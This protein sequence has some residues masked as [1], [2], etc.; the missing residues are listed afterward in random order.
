MRTRGR[1]GRAWLGPWPTTCLQHFEANPAHSLVEKAPPPLEPA[2]L[3]YEMAK[4][5]VS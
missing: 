3:T 1:P 2:Q 4:A 5:K